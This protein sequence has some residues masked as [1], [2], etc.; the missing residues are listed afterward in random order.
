MHKYKRK[1]V[2]FVDLFAFK[3]TSYFAVY[4]DHCDL[5]AA[6]MRGYDLDFFSKDE[7]TPVHSAKYKKWIS[8]QSFLK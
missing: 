5:V 7:D 6:I 1:D 2:E 8:N 4:F 3:L